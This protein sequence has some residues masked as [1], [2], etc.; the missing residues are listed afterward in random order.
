MTLNDLIKVLDQ[1]SVSYSV[2]SLTKVTAH[3]TVRMTDGSYPDEF[4]EL[5][6]DDDT[7]VRTPDGN[8]GFFR[9]LGY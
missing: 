7:I 1:H 4:I 2:E 8:M 3:N 5:M 9:W 6:T